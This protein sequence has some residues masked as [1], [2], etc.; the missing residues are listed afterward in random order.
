MQ[1]PAL[2]HFRINESGTVGD[3]VDPNAF[4]SRLEDLR[5]LEV[6]IFDL[7]LQQDVSPLPPRVFPSMFEQVKA[8]TTNEG[9]YTIE[10]EYNEVHRAYHQ[11]NELYYFPACN[12][13]GSFLDYTSE[14]DNFLLKRIATPLGLEELAEVAAGTTFTVSLVFGTL[15]YLIAN[16]IG[17]F[18][19]S[20]FGQ[21][22]EVDHLA[23]R[24]E[25]RS[26]VAERGGIFGNMQQNFVDY[27]EENMASSAA[28]SAEQPL[29]TTGSDEIKSLFAGLRA[30]MSSIWAGA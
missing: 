25:E 24:L 5:P 14:V 7:G 13:Q 30:N 15:F 8:L 23:D 2:I 28:A 12:R 17:Q 20:F 11:F 3:D 9:A 4:E 27:L 19:S 26:A 1:Y 10:D 16:P 18:W 29:V 21:P 6:R 22:T